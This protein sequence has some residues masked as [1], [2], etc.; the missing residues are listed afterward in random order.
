MAYSSH[1]ASPVRLLAYNLVSPHFDRDVPTAPTFALSATREV[2][3]SAGAIN[4]LQILLLCG[5]V[6]SSSLRALNITAL[7]EHP[8]VGQHLSDHPY[9][10]I[11]FS[12]ARAQDDL[13]DAV[14]R[15]Q[16]LFGSLFAEWQANRTGLFAKGGSSQIGWFRIPDED[17]VSE[18]KGVV[19]PSAGRTSPNYEV[20]FNVAVHSF[21]R[22]ERRRDLE[23]ILN[24]VY[25]LVGA[26]RSASPPLLQVT[27][28]RWP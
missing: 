16:T 14:A 22:L 7:V 28:C 3:L 13:S 5:I 9:V 15:N 25:S 6:P 18:E 19:D 2:I 11:Q 27:S 12:A 4:T 21:W 8:H 1:N 20:T 23:G 24:S 26:H 10:G 17:P